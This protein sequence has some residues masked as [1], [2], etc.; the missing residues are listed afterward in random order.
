MNKVFWEYLHCFVIVY[1]DDILIYFQNLAEH[2]HHLKQ[3]LHKLSEFQ[4][5]LKLK[6][7]EFH[8]DTIHFLSHH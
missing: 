1:I 2:C 5:F 6:K 8:Q 3:V 4:L 7:C